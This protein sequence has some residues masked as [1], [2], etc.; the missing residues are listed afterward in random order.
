[1]QTSKPTQQSRC[2]RS[3]PLGPKRFSWGSQES[4]LTQPPSPPAPPASPDSAISEEEDFLLIKC[5]CPC[6]SA[7]PSSLTPAAPSVDN[8]DRGSD[9]GS[10]QGF[11]R[12][13]ERGSEDSS[14][15]ATPPSLPSG[16][17]GKVGD[18]ID[19]LLASFF[20]DSVKSAVLHLIRKYQRDYCNGCLTD[21]PSQ[22]QHQCLDMLCNK[23]YHDRFYTLMRRLCTP[24]FIPAI[25]HMLTLRNIKA[26]DSKVQT[27]VQTLLH[28]LKSARQIKEVIHAMYDDL[29]AKDVVKISQLRMVTDCGN[30][31]DTL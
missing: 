22:K 15:S 25:Q 13:S 18:E 14:P 23:F 19:G 27:V 8:Q 17:E 3:T 11:D 1:M 7:P 29:V 21:H 16:L 31:G 5:D 6:G 30:G 26:D 12:G 28:E 20:I 4:L 2:L 9:Q 10:D 24:R